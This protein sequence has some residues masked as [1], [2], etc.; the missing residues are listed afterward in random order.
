MKQFDKITDAQ[1][2]RRGVQALADRPNQTGQFGES[3][4]TAAQVKQHFDGLSTYLALRLNNFFETMASEAATEYICLAIEEYEDLHELIAAFASGDFAK[5]LLKVKA[6]A[7]AEE[8][9]SLQSVLN[10]FAKE[11]NDR[12]V[13]IVEEGDLRRVYAIEK[14]GDQSSLF[15]SDEGVATPCAIPVYDE[16]GN[17]VA[18]NLITALEVAL[19][20][21][22]AE[23]R[24]SLMTGKESLDV[25][26]ISRDHLAFLLDANMK[27]ATIVSVELTSEA[28][29]RFTM[30]DGSIITTENSIAGG[31]GGGEG[32]GNS[33]YTSDFYAAESPWDSRSVTGG[34]YHFC[35]ARYTLNGHLT[36]IDADYRI[37]VLPTGAATPV[38]FRYSCNAT[39]PYDSGMRII[40]CPPRIIFE[41]ESKKSVVKHFRMY[42]RPLASRGTRSYIVARDE[43]GDYN[44]VNVGLEA[45]KYYIVGDTL[46]A[47]VKHSNA[48]CGNIPDGISFAVEGRK[49][50]WTES[51]VGGYLNEDSLPEIDVR[52]A[53]ISARERELW[54]EINTIGGEVS[55]A[56]MNL[57]SKGGELSSIA[58]RPQDYVPFQGFAGCDSLTV[59]SADWAN[60]TS[61]YNLS[62]RATAP[63]ASAGGDDSRAE[64]EAS[65]VG[66]IGNVGKGKADFVRGENNTNTG[67][68]S[69]VT[70]TGNDNTGSN[71][72]INGTGNKN[73]APNSDVSGKGNTN[74]GS[75]SAIAG[76]NNTNTGALSS[77]SGT[78]NV[79]HASNV[80][81]RGHTNTNEGQ[82]AYIHGY[83]NHN[84]G[85]GTARCDYVDMHGTRLSAKRRC[86]MLRGHWNKED[87]RAAAVWGNGSGESDR[88]NCF[89]IAA[90]GTPEVDTD[91]ITLGYFNNVLKEEVVKA[92]LAKLPVYEGEFEYE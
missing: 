25:G 86:Q 70:G 30:A 48:D 21:E 55:E 13:Q 32:G 75:N 62:S 12:V 10:T 89:T 36:E 9:E 90:S 77:I 27:K 56:H 11:I 15:V 38:F 26:V 81:M 51:G 78:K 63:Y 64:G 91:G 79:N 23:I 43:N 88:R 3:G 57:L 35:V 33:C 82:H 54:I 40:F 2:K 17:L 47:A 52:E 87:A 46:F 60:K 69:F 61:N 14:S 80:V 44:T 42:E 1:I 7:S 84:D 29:L 22:R 50:V 85:T 8:L 58:L 76:E 74:S 4:L 39:Y 83:E 41:D 65:D 59:Y 37:G 5:R 71:S 68:S 73:S 49:Y 34:S 20:E 31:Q 19:D 28:R 6:G 67:A 45:G 72:S 24:L 92:A 16:N 18:A 66:G 53:S